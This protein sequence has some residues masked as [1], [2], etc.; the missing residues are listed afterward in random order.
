MNS[1]KLKRQEQLFKVDH[2]DMYCTVSCILNA[3]FHE[4]KM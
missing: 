2:A 4:T 1:V 3:L